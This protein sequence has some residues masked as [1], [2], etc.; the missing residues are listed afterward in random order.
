M[1]EILTSFLIRNCSL[2]EC[3]PFDCY[4][5]SK[6]DDAIKHKILSMGILFVLLNSYVNK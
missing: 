2:F 1:N 5:F 6:E 3:F 4:I